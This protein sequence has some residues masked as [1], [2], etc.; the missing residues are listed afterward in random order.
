MCLRLVINET[1]FRIMSV[2][3]PLIAVTAFWAVIGGGGP[4]LVPSGPNRGISFD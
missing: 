4:F 2:W 3:I 1:L